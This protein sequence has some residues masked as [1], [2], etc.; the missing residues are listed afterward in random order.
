M[1]TAFHVNGPAVLKTGTG[2]SAALE[3]LGVCEDKVRISINPILGEV[4]ADSA[5]EGGTADVQHFNSTASIR[6]RLSTYDETVLAKIRKLAGSADGK[7]PTPGTLMATAG[8]TYRLVIPSDDLPWRFY[9]CILRNSIPV[10]LGT[11]Y[12]TWDLEFFAWAFTPGTAVT[13]A[14]GDLYDHTAT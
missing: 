1:A 12:T 9:T 5:G 2:A 6:A 4:R 11:K 3:L 10:E 7:V 8:F 14:A 13:S